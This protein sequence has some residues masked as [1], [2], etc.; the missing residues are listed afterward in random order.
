MTTSLLSWC[1]HIY[2][3]EPCLQVREHGS[4][5]GRG[6]LPDLA[7]GCFWVLSWR[8]QCSHESPIR[9][10]TFFETLMMSS[11][12]H[13]YRGPKTKVVFE[14]LLCFS[15]A[16]EVKNMAILKATLYLFTLL[17]VYIYTSQDSQPRNIKLHV[18]L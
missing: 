5:Q 6:R 15:W 14:S 13:C 18:Q 7:A 8:E 9:Q 16:S 4:P 10:S 2:T 1:K 3:K 11:E 12:R 17:F